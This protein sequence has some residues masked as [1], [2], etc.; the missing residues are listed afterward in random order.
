MRASLSAT[1]SE[2]ESPKAETRSGLWPERATAALMAH[3]SACSA[4]ERSMFAW[5]A[6]RSSTMR[7]VRYSRSSS[8]IAP[9][10]ASGR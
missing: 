8:F 10:S 2:S 3:M 4:T 9:A 7:R 5:I 1:T 6:D